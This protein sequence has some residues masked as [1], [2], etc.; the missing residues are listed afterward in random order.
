MPTP[1]PR[2]PRPRPCICGGAVPLGLFNLNEF[3]HLMSRDLD[4]E[5]VGRSIRVLLPK[6]RE[7][8]RR[9]SFMISNETKEGTNCLRSQSAARVADFLWSPVE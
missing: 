4:G 1:P 9:V 3:S 8:E 6:A 7:E 2:G 5:R